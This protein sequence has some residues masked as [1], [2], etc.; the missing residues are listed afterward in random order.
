MRPHEVGMLNYRGSHEAGH[1]HKR[2]EE[3]E[4][5]EG[6]AHERCAMGLEIV[7][8]RVHQERQQ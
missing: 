5:H 2:E 6:A 8:L 1:A 7:G 3:G 4:E